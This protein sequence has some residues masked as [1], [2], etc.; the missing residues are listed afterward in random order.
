MS[1]P[2][3][4]LLLGLLPVSALSGWWAA[5]RYYKRG[6]QRHHHAIS[7]NYFRGLNYLLNEQPDKAIEVF[8]KLAEINTETAETHLALG[9]LFRRRGEVD[10]AIRF[11]R[12]IISRSSLSEQHRTQA[13]LE[14]GEDY[15]RAGLLDRAEKLFS[16][17][18][19]DGRYS[20]VAIRNLL[21]IYQQEKDWKNAIVQARKLQQVCDH[22]ASAVIAQF[23]CELAIESAQAGDAGNARRH[24]ATAR[25]HHAE[26]TRAYLAE[27]DLDV[28]EQQWAAA[29]QKYQAACELDPDI[30]V[31]V[32][33][34]L[35]RCFSKMGSEPL[36]LD[37][38]ESLVTRG[39]TLAPVLAFA[40]IR[41]ESDPS[42]AI[43]FLL[44]QLQERPTA[45]GLY[46][47]LEL[48]HRHGHRSDEIDPSLLRNLMH[49]L[50]ADQPRFRCRQCG[51]SGQT[52]HWQ[53][54]SCREWETTR[55]V[56]GVLGE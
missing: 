56:I 14:L 44:G 8:L 13:L 9:N 38:L 47:L 1:E 40:A 25:S 30:T 54:P 20:E 48:M 53:C 21:S 27:A 33:E 7:S 49:R 2:F 12:H 22:D 3:W 31:L 4:L 24:L 26:C 19:D 55:P 42:S 41:A 35:S 18:T 39:S 6:E 10:K 43:H 37:W 45:R 29:A 5:S 52:W 23:H 51:F 34:S 50:L 46:Q 15:M 11:H 36:L 28:E 16:E 17:L 32:V